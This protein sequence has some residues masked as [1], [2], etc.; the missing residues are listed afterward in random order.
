MDET[1]AEVWKTCVLLF[2]QQGG[3][4]SGCKKQFWGLVSSKKNSHWIIE[5]LM[6]ILSLSVQFWAKM[7]V[8][9]SPW[10]QFDWL[11]GHNKS[12][13]KPKMTLKP[14]SVTVTPSILT[15]SLCPNYIK[16]SLLYRN[17]N[18]VLQGTTFVFWADRMNTLDF[19][20][21][22]SG[23]L[24]SYLPSLGSSRTLSNPFV[25]PNCIERSGTHTSAL[26]KVAFQ[27]RVAAGCRGL[28]SR[29]STSSDHRVDY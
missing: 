2:G 1:E 28:E 10:L 25:R 6:S 16:N 22:K 17:V 14:N 8:K 29:A 7:T 26:Q 19:F 21:Q 9:L 27:R 15:Y 20:L 13:R 24:K 18:M 12:N 23:F 3:D 4:T 11:T 5:T